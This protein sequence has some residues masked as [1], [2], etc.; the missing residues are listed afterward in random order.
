LHSQIF[1]RFAA[2][3]LLSNSLKVLPGKGPDLLQLLTIVALFECS[4]LTPFLYF[5]SNVSN[6]VKGVVRYFSIV[7]AIK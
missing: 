3:F 2:N 7:G 5:L 4:A 6:Q 1:S